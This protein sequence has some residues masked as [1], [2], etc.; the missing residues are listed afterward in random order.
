MILH[1]I[2]THDFFFSLRVAMQGRE[3]FLNLSDKVAVDLFR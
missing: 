3:V 1:R 2:K